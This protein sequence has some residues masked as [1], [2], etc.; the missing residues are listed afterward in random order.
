MGLGRGYIR[1]RA[2]RNV[3]RAFLER[4]EQAAAPE[5][6]STAARSEIF[7]NYPQSMLSSSWLRLMS[8]EGEPP[9][10]S[11]VA[12]AERPWAFTEQPCPARF[13]PW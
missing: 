10:P 13:L 5:P 8:R 2:F 4:S 11:L 6:S 3:L 9:R 7:S 12:F 1:S